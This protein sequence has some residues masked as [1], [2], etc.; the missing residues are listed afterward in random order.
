MTV[1]QTNFD[2]DDYDVFTCYMMPNTLI[3]RLEKSEVKI[4]ILQAANSA[5]VCTFVYDTCKL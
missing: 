4:E 1:L 3:V 5:I 2:K